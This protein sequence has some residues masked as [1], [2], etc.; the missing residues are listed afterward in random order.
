MTST[1]RQTYLAAK[2]EEFNCSVDT[3]ELIHDAI[4]VELDD[5][6]LY[7]WQEWSQLEAILN[8]GETLD[9]ADATAISNLITELQ[10]I[11][12]MC[13]GEFMDDFDAAEDL[14]N[15]HNVVT[16]DDDHIAP[17]PDN[18]QDGDV[19]N[20]DA[21]ADEGDS[22]NFPDNP[23]NYVD[24]DN[25]LHY[26]DLNHD[27]IIENSDEDYIYDED[28]N[29][30][31]VNGDGVVSELDSPEYSNGTNG[32]VVD[33]S[34]IPENAI[35][36]FMDYDGTADPPSLRIKVTLAD[37]TF[38]YYNILGNPKII[39][40]VLPVNID[41]IPEDLAMTIYS[42]ATTEH[43]YGYSLYGH[44]YNSDVGYFTRVEMS[45]R[46]N[47]Y[48][49]DP[50]DE[51]FVNGREYTVT[52]DSETLDTLTIDAEDCTITFEY[53][54]GN[55]VIVLTNEDGDQVRIICEGLELDTSEVNIGDVINFE[56]G[57]IDEST[58]ASIEA[59]NV[60]LAGANGY[61]EGGL[62]HLINL[63]DEKLSDIA[64][65]NGYELTG[66]SVILTDGPM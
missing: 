43:S 55:V 66:R 12:D 54:N 45:D 35:V 8:S 51:D 17:D 64:E 42:T 59:I 37:G 4:E 20:I 13:D 38:Y 22:T 25:P 10:S 18:P 2:F 39:L 63:D 7:L 27:G 5:W 31:D 46:D 24:P 32:T 34:S 56:G 29:L 26:Q 19:Y 36:N 14:F 57:I 48:E 21:T 58:Y 40:P 41:S 50:S 47:E 53:E 6:A 62:F 16:E 3:I 44:D 11:Q 52:F 60:N 30:K 23:L 9:T 33:L 61:T 49:I 65:E 15:D 1:E 28:G